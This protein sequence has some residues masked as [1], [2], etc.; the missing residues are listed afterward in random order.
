MARV[1]SLFATL[2]L[3]LAAPAAFA[4]TGDVDGNG[5]VDQ[6]DKEIVV[7]AL[8]SHIGEPGYVAAA[9]LDGD[10]IISSTDLVGVLK[11]IQD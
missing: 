5:V 8:G 10:G 3:L 9:D 2:A 7:A 4:S 6:A 11:Q 1:L